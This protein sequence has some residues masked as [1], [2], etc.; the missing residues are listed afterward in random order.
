[1]K[2][3]ATCLPGAVLIVFILFDTF[4]IPKE[5]VASGQEVSRTKKHVGGKEQAGAFKFADPYPGAPA[6]KLA[7][8]GLEAIK[9]DTVLVYYSKEKTELAGQIADVLEQ[10]NMLTHE[11]VGIPIRIHG[12]VL[13]ADRRGL[14][15]DL[16]IS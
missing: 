16:R 12:L 7:G 2:R 11:I 1:M 8:V 15:A 5:D 9:R 10:M 4:W 13:I 14:P 3:Q 6:R